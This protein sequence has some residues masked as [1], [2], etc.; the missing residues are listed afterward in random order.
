[1]TFYNVCPAGIESGGPELAH[2]MCHRLDELGCDAKM[3]YITSNVI[4]PQ[5]VPASGKYLKYN[6]QHAV[7]LSE[8][9]NPQSVVIFNEG[10]TGLIP[11]VKG[12]R[13]VLWWMS[14]DNYLINTDGRDIDVIRQ[15][16]ELHIVQSKYAYEYV[17][18]VVKADE[19]HIMY[20]SDYI[21]DIYMTE[22]PEIP[23]HNIALYNP[24]KGLDKIKPLIERISW[25]KWVPLIGL[26]EEDMVAYM[27][28]AKIYIDF[29][30]HPGK[31]R[32]PREA[33]TCGC[34]I[35]TNRK[36][37]AVFYEDVSIPDKYKF[38]SET[39]Y[40]D[41]EQRIRYICDNFYEA[42]KDFDE[43]RMRIRQEKAKFNSDVENFS[44]FFKLWG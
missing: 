36:G 23:R 10:A 43:Y 1:M 37:S 32:I 27:H 7:S 4:E 40:D 24:K 8:I 38:G 18:N 15:E 13:K 25:L 30:N 9:E 29:G 20:V 17:R 14:V 44:N 28:I 39:D 5:D 16:N 26:T 42:K 19:S 35:I 22:V 34:C 41:I 2:Q 33:A 3:Y 31:D 6:T 11:L 21:G 12:C